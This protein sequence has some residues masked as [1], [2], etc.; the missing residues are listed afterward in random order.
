MKIQVLT[1]TI[2]LFAAATSLSAQGNVYCIDLAQTDFEHYDLL[3]QDIDDKKM[4]MIGEMHYMAANSILQTDLWIHLNKQRGV[5]HLLIE[6]GEAEAYLYNQYLQTGDAWYLRHTFQGFNHYEQFMSDWKTLYEYNAGLDKDKKLVVHGLDLEREP[7]LSAAMY[8]L[9]APYTENPQVESLR[10][11]IQARLDTIGVER[12]TLAYTNVLRESISALSPTEALPE[13]ENKRIISKILE[14]PSNYLE[15]EK[16]D[17]NMAQKFQELDTIDAVYLGQFGAGHAMLNGRDVLA[18]ILHRQEDYKDK[19]LVMNMF[20][21][22]QDS[23]NP[24]PFEA[25]SDCPVFLYRIDPADPQLKGWSKRGQWVLVLRD[26]P[27]YA[28]QK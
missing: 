10:D 7:G 21:Q 26:Q 3:N 12:N 9:L 17:A 22:R 8:S 20:D 11:S 1:T 23:N 27:S 4:V 14:N 19:I 15:L 25:V 18:G 13:G 6:F 2:L 28:R 16:R 5:R 24:A